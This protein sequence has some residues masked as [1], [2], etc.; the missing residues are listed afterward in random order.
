[1][2]ATS[3]YYRA[4]T[5]TAHKRGLGRRTVLVD[6]PAEPFDETLEPLAPAESPAVAESREVAGEHA[7]RSGG[8][9]VEALRRRYGEWC[10]GGCVGLDPIEAL[11]PIHECP[12]GKLPEDRRQTCSCWRLLAAPDP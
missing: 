9:Y 7:N 6:P 8:A 11:D 2:T 4:T 12:H 1:M 5:P 3:P 10:A